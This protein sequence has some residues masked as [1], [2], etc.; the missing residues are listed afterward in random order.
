MSN[1]V[2]FDFD[3]EPRAVSQDKTPAMVK[4]VIKLSGGL[5]K[6]ERQ[7]N[8]ILLGF[9]VMALGLSFYLF[10]GGGTVVGYPED[11]KMLP[12]VF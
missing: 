4:L 5:I 10:F 2:E 9:V 1:G 12:A 6:D 3:N 8:W 7:A 11:I